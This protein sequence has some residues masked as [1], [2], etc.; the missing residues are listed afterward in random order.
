MARNAVVA[1]QPIGALPASL[2]AVE[3]GNPK[4]LRLSRSGSTYE[5]DGSFQPRSILERYAARSR[6][7]SRSAGELRRRPGGAGCWAPSR[8]PG[9]GPVS[10]SCSECSW[11]ESTVHHSPRASCP[12]RR[13]DTVSRQRS[14][15]LVSWPYVHRKQRPGSGEKPFPYSC[16][17]R[18]GSARPVTSDQRAPRQAPSGGPSLG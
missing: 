2:Q 18:Q 8:A 5:L 3:P 6:R 15:G 7:P 4:T 12:H 14:G 16:I 11:Q 1:T 17:D 10:A 13:V 9:P